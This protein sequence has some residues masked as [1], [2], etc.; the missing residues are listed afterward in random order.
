MSTDG[1]APRVLIV[2]DDVEIAQALQRSLRLEGYEVRLAPDG[3]RALVL[4]AAIRARTSTRG[5][6]HLP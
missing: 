6:L 1:R 3:E 2:E 4:R 5:R